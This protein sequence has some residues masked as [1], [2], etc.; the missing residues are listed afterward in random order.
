[1]KRCNTMNFDWDDQKTTM[2]FSELKKNKSIEEI[3]FFMQ[4][5]PASIE[6]RIIKFMENKTNPELKDLCSLD[7]TFLDKEEIIYSYPVSPSG[8]L[9]NNIHNKIHMVKV[10]SNNSLNSIDSQISLTDSI[11]E[12]VKDTVEHEM[13][14]MQEYLEEVKMQEKENSIM[15]NILLHKV[16]KIEKIFV[17]LYNH[18]NNVG[19]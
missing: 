9:R 18:V 16:G 5:S 15:M 19:K 6:W 4:K 12:I 2:L 8:H 1:M 17:F 11:K 10:K 3:A 7:L 14:M 13:K